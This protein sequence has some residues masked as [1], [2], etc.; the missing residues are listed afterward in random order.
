MY[1]SPAACV[2]E[3]RPV[4]CTGTSDHIQLCLQLCLPQLRTFLTAWA[5]SQDVAMA[6]AL[7]STAA[8]GEQK[9]APADTIKSAR[10][11]ADEL[12]ELQ[13]DNVD[14]RLKN[15][16]RVFGQLRQ[17]CSSGGPDGDGKGATAEE[18]FIAAMTAEPEPLSLEAALLAG[19]DSG[20]ETEKRRAHL[21]S[22]RV[23]EA[24]RRRRKAA[25]E[26]LARSAAE[27]AAA[28]ARGAPPPLRGGWRTPA[29]LLPNLLSVWDFLGT[30]ADQLW[31]PPIP[32]ARLDAALSPDA[33]APAAADEAAAIVLRD[34]HCAF[35]RVLEGRAGKGAQPPSIP[36]LRSGRTNVIPCVGDHHWQAR[37]PTPV[38]V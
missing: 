8:P 38:V 32:L 9:L 37:I 4:D 22:K 35:L 13:A 10:R 19:S 28:A 3:G 12:R 20:T 11:L 14:A 6:A 18:D 2:S 7:G 23:Y 17:H 15:I 29:A 31:L 33:E 21:E 25:E 1:A 36:V 27:A 34:V 24:E 5:E 16:A 30:F 26:D